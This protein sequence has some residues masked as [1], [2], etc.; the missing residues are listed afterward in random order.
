MNINDSGS[1][2]EDCDEIVYWVLGNWV[3]KYDSLARNGT[4]CLHVARFIQ[5][6]REEERPIGYV[7]IEILIVI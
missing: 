6:V 2:L 4:F 7:H 3:R 5:L 1:I